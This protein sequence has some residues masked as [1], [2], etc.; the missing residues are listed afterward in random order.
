[1]FKKELNMYRKFVA[2]KNI[3]IYNLYLTTDSV[4]K[5]ITQGGLSHLFL[6]YSIQLIIY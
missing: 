1:M 5:R 4:M 2:M 6:L 3:Y